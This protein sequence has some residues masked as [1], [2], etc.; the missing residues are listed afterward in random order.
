[1]PNQPNNKQYNSI[2]ISKH[3]N[4]SA[5]GAE[6]TKYVRIYGTNLNQPRVTDL[7][8]AYENEINLDY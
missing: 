8:I 6:A 4:G 2:E 5:N 3:P 7:Y 1:M